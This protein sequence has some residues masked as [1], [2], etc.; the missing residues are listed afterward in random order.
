MLGIQLTRQCYRLIYGLVRG[1][2]LEPQ[3][4]EYKYLRSACL[5][6]SFVSQFCHIGNINQPTHPETQ[7]R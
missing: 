3:P 6:E 4:V 1:M 5:R 7:N 2:F